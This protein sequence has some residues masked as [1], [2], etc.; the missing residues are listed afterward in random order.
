MRRGPKPSVRYWE[1]RKAY[2][3]YINNVRH[4]LAYGPDDCPTGPTYLEALDQFKKLLSL[5]TNKGTDQYLV[6]ALLD[7]YRAHLKA[8]CPV[9]SR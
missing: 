7:Q 2:C 1:T 3:C 4:F 5:E 9:C 6:S 8:P